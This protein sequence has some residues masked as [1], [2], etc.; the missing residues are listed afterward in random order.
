[1]TRVWMI[2]VL[3]CSPILLI[4]DFEIWDFL[5]ISVA[6]ALTQGSLTL[7][8]INTHSKPKPLWAESGLLQVDLCR[9]WA[10]LSQIHLPLQ[11][12]IRRDPIILKLLGQVLSIHLQPRDFFQA[13]RSHCQRLIGKALNFDETQKADAMICLPSLTNNFLRF[14]NPSIQSIS[15]K[16]CHL[17]ISGNYFCILYIQLE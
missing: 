8:K 16:R 4:L 10:F 9:K 5:S 2:N 1:M 15:S 6:W 12:T 3:L 7:H 14:S 13:H 17:E 11:C